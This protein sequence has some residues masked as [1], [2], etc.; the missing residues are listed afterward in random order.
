MKFICKNTK[1]NQTYEYNENEVRDLFEYDGHNCTWSDNHCLKS[2][3]DAYLNELEENIKNADDED[4]ILAS[5]EVKED[6][7][8]YWTN[9][10]RYVYDDLREYLRDLIEFENWTSPRCIEPVFKVVEVIE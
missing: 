6:Y 8:K 1:N 4:E 10:Y 7:I 9:E 5:V 3:Y 2:E